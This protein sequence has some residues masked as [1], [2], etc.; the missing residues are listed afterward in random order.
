VTGSGW[1]DI[2]VASCLVLFL[3][4]SAVRVLTSAKA[5]ICRET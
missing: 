3:M 1:P 5:E 2:V 4:R